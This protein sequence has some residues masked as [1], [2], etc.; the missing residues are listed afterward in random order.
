M[1]SRSQMR[2]TWSDPVLTKMTRGRVNGVYDIQKRFRIRKG[3]ESVADLERTY[4]ELIDF[5]KSHKRIYLFGTLQMSMRYDE[6]LKR[7]GISVHGFI[8]V[9]PQKY[10]QYQEGLSVPVWRFEEINFKDAA[11]DIGVIL[12]LPTDLHPL[13]YS[14]LPYETDIYFTVDDFIDLL[15]DREIVCDAL[16]QLRKTSPAFATAPIDEGYNHILRAFCLLNDHELFEKNF[17]MTNVQGRDE[18]RSISIDDIGIVMQGPLYKQENF[19]LETLKFYRSIYPNVPIVLSTWKGEG[20]D[21][22][23]NRCRE[24]GVVFLANEKPPGPDWQNVNLQLFSSAMG[25]QL[26]DTHF[27]NVKY[28]LKTRTDMRINMSDFLLYFRSL[29][30]TYPVADDK[31]EA[32]LMFLSC[33][34]VFESPFYICDYMA[35]GTNN[36]MKKLYGPRNPN[37]QDSKDFSR[38]GEYYIARTFYKMYIAPI[39]DGQDTGAYFNFLKNYAVITD[40][41]SLRAQWPKYLSGRHALMN[42]KE[43]M[44]HAKWLSFCYCDNGGVAISIKNNGGDFSIRF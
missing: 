16:E 3:P 15:Y 30:R 41:M 14:R 20:D 24:L 32:R 33:A 27:K 34:H 43:F 5:C 42:H 38:N 1:S 9:D 12:S 17:L 2:F 11:A 31:L 29:L 39:E 26:I 8:N 25:I 19:T 28:I 21:D 18:I 13:A 44:T 35:F 22:F 37:A 7:K 40:L 10:V 6:L 23:I 4:L 36:D